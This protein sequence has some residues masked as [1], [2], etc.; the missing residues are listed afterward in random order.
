MTKKIKKA[1][2]LVSLLA[3]L[4]MFPLDASAVTLFN[5]EGT[6]TGTSVSQTVD[7]ITATVTKADGSNITVTGPLGPASWLNASLLAND[8]AANLIINFSV[9]VSGVSLEWGDFNQDSDENTLQAYAGAGGTGALLGSDTE[10]IPST[11][12]IA[13]G[14]SGTADLVVNVAGIQSVLILSPL[15]SD[16]EFPY[17]FFFDN[18]RVNTQQVPEPATVLLLGAGLLSLA[19]A[20]YRTSRA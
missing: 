4:S 1:G 20:A 18:L 6:T 5:F 7:G 17:S 8:S 10:F 9:A 2:L 16:N 19:A 13:D 12:T 15:S 14:D 3:L 11:Q